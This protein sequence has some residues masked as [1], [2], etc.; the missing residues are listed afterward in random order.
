VGGEPYDPRL[1]GR[2]RDKNAK[3]RQLRLMEDRLPALAIPEPDHGRIDLDALLPNARD[4]WLEVGFGGG[5]NLVHAAAAHPDVLMLG[6]E[7]FVN[8][9]GKLLAA[10]EGR[11]LRNI[12]I[13][14]GDARPLME[15]LPDARLGRLYVLHPDP[16]PK[17]RHWK[18]R[19]VSDWFLDEAA[20][21]LR[22]EGELRVASDS[23]DYI[24]WTLMHVLPRSDFEWT[25][26]RPADWRERPADQPMTRYGAKAERE[27]RTAAYLEFRRA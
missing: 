10:I 22:P 21:L 25:A 9:V 15:A 11:G 19:I 23:P 4:V 13:R 3:P 27:G 14:H 5:E 16:W 17:R 8:G 20:R 18:R 24:A 1:Y 2:R 12:R 6:A 7:P 26:R